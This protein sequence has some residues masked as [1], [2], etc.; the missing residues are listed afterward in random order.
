M[1]VLIHVTKCVKERERERKIEREKEK[2]TRCPKGTEELV[3]TSG[4]IG[5]A[6]RV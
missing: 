3:I 2:S 4:I 5:S 6:D 1:A